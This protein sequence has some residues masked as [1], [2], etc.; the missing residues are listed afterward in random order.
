MLCHALDD[1]PGGVNGTLATLDAARV[2]HVG[3]HG[4]HSATAP[5][6]DRWYAVTTSRGGW[7]VAWVGCQ[8][9]INKSTLWFDAYRRRKARAHGYAKASRNSGLTDV[10]RNILAC[11]RPCY[12]SKDLARAA[13]AKRAFTA[14]DVVR[15]L[16]SGGDR[17]GGAGALDAIVV[18]PHAGPEMNAAPSRAQRRMYRRFAA[19]S[20]FRG[21]FSHIGAERGG[22]DPHRPSAQ[23]S[24]P[25]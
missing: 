7:R 9:F 19:R 18:K 12:Q 25:L 11:D 6:L 23:I 13:R 15:A 1:R 20:R 21:A 8:C 5:R 22:T 4:A 24:A 14:M 17:A 10:S 2:A 16:A 3:T